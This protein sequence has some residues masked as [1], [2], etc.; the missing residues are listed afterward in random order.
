MDTLESRMDAL[1]D[2]NQKAL[3]VFA[4]HSDRMEKMG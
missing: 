1:I 4:R 3:E 2:A